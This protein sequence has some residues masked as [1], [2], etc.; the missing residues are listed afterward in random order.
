MGEIT[1]PRMVGTKKLMML[2][3]DYLTSNQS[4]EC[5][6]ADYALFNHDYKVPHYPLQAGTRSF[7]GIR[8]L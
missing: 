3:P 5:P 8:S 2:T 7:E 4:E 1:D 6:Q